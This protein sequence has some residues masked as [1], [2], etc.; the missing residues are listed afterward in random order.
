MQHMHETHQYLSNSARIQSQAWLCHRFSWRFSLC[1]F[2]A[3]AL[4]RA[5]YA[6]PFSH[7][8]SFKFL[9]LYRK[10]ILMLGYPCCDD[11]HVI[12]GSKRDYTSFLSL[13]ALWTAGFVLYWDQICGLWYCSQIQLD[14][15]YSI[16]RGRVHNIS[17]TCL[18][19]IYAKP[20]AGT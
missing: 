11:P 2:H 18:R 9:S 16:A 5:N 7:W 15:F 3:Y 1:R 20:G 13:S 19:R 6:S 10:A 17:W 4:V 8:V 12:Y 14:C